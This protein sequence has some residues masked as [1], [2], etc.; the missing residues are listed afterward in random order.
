MVYKDE[1]E[2][3]KAISD[4]VAAT[5]VLLFVKGTRNAPMCGFSKGVMD[6]FDQ[7]GAEYNTVDVLADPMI[8]EGIKKFTSWPTIPQIFI[9]GEFVGGFDI[10]RDLHSRGELQTMLKQAIA[11]K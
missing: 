11:A 9:G 5:P 6:V 8:R 3:Q 7:L 10:V 4:A 1:Q 2:V